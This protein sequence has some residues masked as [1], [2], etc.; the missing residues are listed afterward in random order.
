V[1]I[2]SAR[3]VSDSC[4][5]QYFAAAS[6]RV[7]QPRD[8]TLPFSFVHEDLYDEDGYELEPQVPSFA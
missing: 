4:L 2:L 3:E 1:L 8:L 7:V 6:Q 5:T